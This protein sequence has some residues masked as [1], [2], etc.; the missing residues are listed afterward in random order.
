MQKKSLKREIDGVFLLNKPLGFSSNQALKKIQWLLAPLLRRGVGV[1]MHSAD[2]S[3]LK[4]LPGAGAGY[5][6]PR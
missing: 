2:Q 1:R 5:A 3:F 6:R 4:K